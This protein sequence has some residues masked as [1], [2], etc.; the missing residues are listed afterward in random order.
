MDKYVC[1]YKYVCI[2][3]YAYM[4]VFIHMYN[5]RMYLYTC[6]MYVCM[7]TRVCMYSKSGYKFSKTDLQV[8]M[9]DL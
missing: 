8:K 3:T 4:Y 7:Y 9:Q 1:M 6:I 2:H 5:V